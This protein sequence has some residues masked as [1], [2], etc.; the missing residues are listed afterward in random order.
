ML[1]STRT[2]SPRV[3]LSPF[4]GTAWQV[5]PDVSDEMYDALVQRGFTPID[6]KSKRK[7]EHADGTSETDGR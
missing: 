4:N 5:P 2:E 6:T 7:K 3:L 1:D